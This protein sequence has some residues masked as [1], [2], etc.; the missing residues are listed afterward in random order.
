MKNTVTMTLE[1]AKKDLSAKKGMLTRAKKTEDQAKIAAAQSALDEAQ[2]VFN[3][4]SAMQTASENEGEEA[5]A[6][7]DPKGMNATIDEV[8]DEPKQEEGKADEKTE[9]DKLVK[10]DVELRALVKQYNEAFRFREDTSSIETKIGDKVDEYTQE[11]M[12]RCFT[13]LLTKENPMLEAVKKLTF[14]T[15]RVSDEKVEG[16]K[17]GIR[18]DDATKP[19]DPLRLHHDSKAGIG[20][21]PYWNAMI[22]KLGMLLACRRAIEL[23]LD[24]LAVKNTYSMSEQALK[25]EVL[26]SETD[27]K[28]YDKAAADEVL[29][30]DLQNVVNAMLGEGFTISEHEVNYLLMIY[31]KK[32]RSALTVSLAKP[33]SMRLYLMEIC[34]AAVTHTAYTLDYKKKK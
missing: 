18:V 30:G 25:I 33:Q 5:N 19:I 12:K 9:Q 32:G 17:V 15:L 23:G 31:Q 16:V 24:P 8:K 4:V 20:A 14:P 7:N 26:R 29:K 22:E 10:I 13:E 28:K 21:D 34:Y 1:Q 2:K 3:E 11:S 6:M 27:S